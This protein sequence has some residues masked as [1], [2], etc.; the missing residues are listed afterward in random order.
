MQLQNKHVL[1]ATKNKGKVQEFAHHFAKL[2]IEVTSLLDVPNAPDIVEDGDTFAANALIKARALADTYKLPVLA[3]DSGLCVNA[4]NGAPGIYSARYAGEGATDALNNLKL[5]EELHKIDASSYLEDGFLSAAQFVCA[6]V[7]Y[8]PAT[9]ET[10]E[11]SGQVEGFIVP[12]PRGVVGFGY[13]PY[14]YVPEYGLTM[15]ELTIDQKIKIS[16]R[17]QALQQLLSKL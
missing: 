4:L 5:M 15:A 2:G 14:F 12:E 10:L 13:D 9:E 16:H 6:L 1:I 17:G 11:A 3:D 8:D 7:L